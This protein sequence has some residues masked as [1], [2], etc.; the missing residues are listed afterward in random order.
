MPKNMLSDDCRDE[1]TTISVV[2]R[3]HAK[4][5]DCKVRRRTIFSQLNT[6]LLDK[7]NVKQLVYFEKKS[8]VLK[9]GDAQPYLYCIREGWCRMVYKDS[10]EKSSTL[11]YAGPGDVLGLSSICS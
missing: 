1:K 9:S 8:V 7:P 10:K 6:D 4:C 3:N 11:W 2:F 5:K